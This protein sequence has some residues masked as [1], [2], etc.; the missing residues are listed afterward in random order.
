MLEVRVR[1]S[2]LH[3]GD[4]AFLK[5]SKHQIHTLIAWIVFESFIVKI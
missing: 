4:F 3:F 5:G 2:T 1:K